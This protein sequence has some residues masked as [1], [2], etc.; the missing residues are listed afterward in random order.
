MEE[1]N[2]KETDFEC[3]KFW[4]KKKICDNC[5]SLRADQENQPYFKMEYKGAKIYF[6]TAVP[7]QIKGHRFVLEMLKSSDNI[8]KSEDSIFIY[9]MIDAMNNRRKLDDL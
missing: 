5:I 7:I 1:A 8:E 3:H 2:V 6:I 4:G 9:S